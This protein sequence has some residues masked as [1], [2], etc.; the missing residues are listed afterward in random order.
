MN[1]KWNVIFSIYAR[2]Q[3]NIWFSIHVTDLHELLV[4]IARRSYHRLAPTWRVT[5]PITTPRSLRGT[6]SIPADPAVP[7]TRWI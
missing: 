5:W 7:S 1:D 2:Q 3:P 4:Y 6:T